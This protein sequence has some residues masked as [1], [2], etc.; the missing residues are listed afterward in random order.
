MATQIN[1]SGVNVTDV[2]ISS[3]SGVNE[4]DKTESMFGVLIADSG[5]K[6]VFT[7]CCSGKRNF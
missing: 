7:K 3:M 2:E 1:A 6:N 5:W 4:E